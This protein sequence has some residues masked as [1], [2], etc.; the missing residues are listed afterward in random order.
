MD[1]ADK[2]HRSLKTSNADMIS[3]PERYKSLASSANDPSGYLH[4][5][6]P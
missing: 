2:L 4:N 1:L 3:M 6:V 5:H